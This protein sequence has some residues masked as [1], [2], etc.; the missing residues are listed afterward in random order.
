MFRIGDNV[1]IVN[2]SE[3][4]CNGKYG[5]ITATDVSYS[6]EQYYEIELEDRPGWYCV[7][8]EDEMMEG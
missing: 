8:T 3:P 6:G 7:A 5:T 2:H 4:Q 1:Q